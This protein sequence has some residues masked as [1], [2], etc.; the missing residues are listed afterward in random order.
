MTI[1]G[2]HNKV[3]LEDILVGEVWVCSGQSNMEWP[4]AASWNAD[5]E[6]ASANQPQ[7][8]LITVQTPG[9]QQPLEDFSG[10][11]QVASPQTVGNFSA[12]GYYFG[13]QLQQILDVPIGLI[14]NSWGGSS[15][16]AWVQ[17]DRLQ[18]DDL[19]GPLMKRWEDQEAKPEW[20]DLYAEFETAWLQ[21]QQAVIAAKKAGQAL[22][23]E[24]ARPDDSA[25]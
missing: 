15:C 20:K 11:W 17:R 7:I 5:L 21:W 22:P 10:Q 23:P 9:I 18:D 13:L 8:R 1:E 12:V 19:Y 16:E 2:E 14:D 6:I 24:P 3:A 25:G 4:V